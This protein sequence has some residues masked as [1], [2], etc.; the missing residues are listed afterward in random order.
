MFSMAVAAVGAVAAASVGIKL[1]Q[2]FD[3]YEP[4]TPAKIQIRSTVP[5]GESPFPRFFLPV[6]AA[7]AKDSCWLV[8]LFSPRSNDSSQG[9]VDLFAVM[10]YGGQPAAAQG[11]F[12]HTP[13]SFREVI[14]SDLRLHLLTSAFSGTVSNKD[15]L[16][17]AED[18]SVLPE[19]ADSLRLLCGD[20]A[21]LYR[22]L[23]R[24]P[25]SLTDHVVNRLAMAAALADLTYAPNLEA[26]LREVVLFTSID[27][28]NKSPRGTAEARFMRK[29]FGFQRQDFY[30]S[31]KQRSTMRALPSSCVADGGLSLAASSIRTRYSLD[32]R[33]RLL[34]LLPSRNEQ[35]RK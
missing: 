1:K 18:S 31:D 9:L 21:A 12:R 28:A 10:G 30:T 27:E 4:V 34:P 29:V 19:V 6:A 14:S 5:N 7:M 2:T 35:P 22:T 13:A 33:P 23:T 20:G 25:G 16:A 26:G 3:A 8:R 24:H 11:Y 15:L 17:R 32:S